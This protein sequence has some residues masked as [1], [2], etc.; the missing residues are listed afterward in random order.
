MEHRPSA[1][2]F[3]TGASA[4]RQRLVGSSAGAARPRKNIKGALRSAQ[5]GQKPVVEC[6]GK[7]R[8]DWILHIKGSRGESRA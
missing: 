6:K 4:L 5:M 3:L 2:A 8:P 1:T 7:S